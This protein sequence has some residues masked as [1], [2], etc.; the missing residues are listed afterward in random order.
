MTSDW[1]EKPLGKVASLQRGHDLP[2]ESRTFGN[3]PVMGSAGITGYH[4]EA[5]ATASG[6][7]IGRSGNSMG[8]AHYSPTAYWPLNTV[9][10]VTDFHGNIPRF[11]YYLFKVTDFKQFNSGSAQQS[12]DRNQVHPYPISIPS[13]E[14]QK[15]IAHILGTLD[16]KIELLRQMNETLEA[17][18]RAL[19]KSWFVDFDPVRKK[20]EGLPTGLPPEIDALFPDSFEDSELGEIPKGWN[21]KALGEVV[22][23]AGG[24]TPSTKDTSFWDGT[25]KFAAPRDLSRLDTP[26]LTDTERSITKQGVSQISSGQL[27]TGTLLLS[28]R[29]PIGYLALTDTPVSINQG[30]IA[31][32]KESILPPQYMY[33]WCKENMETIIGNAN[34]TTFLEISKTNFRTIK[35]VLPRQDIATQFCEVASIMFSKIAKNTHENKALIKIRDSLLPKLISGDLEVKDIDKILE[36]VK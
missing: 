20:A 32:K 31:V 10:Y 14:R 19:F 29:A 33:F 27:P 24:S 21:V 25:Y 16:D 4:N 2:S 36:P 34:G 23:I 1:A 11:I 7:V 12:L 35:A 9:L 15:A 5:R 22:E 30:F 26:I 8:E 17:M 28:S 18:A 3:I 13:I 6:V